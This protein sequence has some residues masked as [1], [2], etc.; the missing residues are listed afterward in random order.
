MKRKFSQ[1]GRTKYALG[2]GLGG[3]TE[4]T[5]GKRTPDRISLCRMILRRWDGIEG[6]SWSVPGL[7]DA[8]EAGELI[9][10]KI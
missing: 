6:E 10:G 8:K 9:I 7:H 5:L 4:P 3:G 1:K 2:Q